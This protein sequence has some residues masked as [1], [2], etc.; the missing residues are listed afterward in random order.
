MEG[1]YFDVN[2]T[3][4]Q[5]SLYFPDGHL[6]AGRFKGMVTILEE[7]GYTGVQELRVECAKFKCPKEARYCCC[8]RLLFT[9][10]DFAGVKSEIENFC[11]E[12]GV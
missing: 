3:Q 8:R 10:P 12:Q 2:G 7:R 6:H 11:K 9:E 4:V 5:Q 1:A